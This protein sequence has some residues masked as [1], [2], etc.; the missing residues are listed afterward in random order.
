MGSNPIG[1]IIRFLLRFLL[2]FLPRL[3]LACFGAF[4]PLGAFFAAAIIAFRSKKIAFQ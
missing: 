4:F 1:L 3:L 2:R